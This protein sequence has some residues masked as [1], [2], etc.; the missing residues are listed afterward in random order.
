MSDSSCIQDYCKGKIEKK[1][2]V[3]RLKNTG[4][5]RNLNDLYNWQVPR[6]SIVGKWLRDLT[7]FIVKDENGFNV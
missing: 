2:I 1:V 6:E 7:Y 5:R 4:A 3:S